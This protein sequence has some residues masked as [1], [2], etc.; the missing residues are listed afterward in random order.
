[1]KSFFEIMRANWMD[2]NSYELIMHWVYLWYVN[3][4]P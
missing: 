2:L 3:Y 1:M 4:Y